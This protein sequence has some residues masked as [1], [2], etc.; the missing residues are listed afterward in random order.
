TEDRRSASF[1]PTVWSFS[2]P[3]ATRRSPGSGWRERAP[4]KH[5][6]PGRDVVPGGVRAEP[7]EGAAVVGGAR[8]IGLDN[9]G[10]SVP[11]AE[12][13]NAPAVG[14]ARRIEERFSLSGEF[15]LA[16]QD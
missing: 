16:G 11:A 6:G 14:A 5:Y 12:R 3:R 1:P 7:G 2:S 8:R 9:L 10:E 4:E 15:D 13:A